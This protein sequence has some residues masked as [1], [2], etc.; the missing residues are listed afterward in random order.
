MWP[1]L[2]IVVLV[3]WI[4]T[5]ARDEGWFSAGFGTAVLVLAILLLFAGLIWWTAVSLNRTERERRL[6]EHR[7]DVLVRVSDLIRTLQNAD[8]D[9][10]QQPLAVR[11]QLVVVLQQTATENLLTVRD[12]LLIYAYLHGV[13][14]ETAQS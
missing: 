1:M 14:P 9:V 7:L 11:E 4:R 3:G 12:N 10:T 5:N 6:A 13:K 2:L 8:V